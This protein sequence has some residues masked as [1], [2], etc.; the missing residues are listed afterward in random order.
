MVK[1]G[2][3]VCA[4]LK[5]ESVNITLINPKQ[6]VPAKESLIELVQGLDQIYTLE[7]HTIIGGYGAYLT[8]IVDKNIY[9]FALPNDF[10]EHGNVNLLHKRLGLDAQSIATELLKQIRSTNG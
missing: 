10:V 6:L 1:V 7:D 9:K 2:I 3:D 4:L 5:E 8:S